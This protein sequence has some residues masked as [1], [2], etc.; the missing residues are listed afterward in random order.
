VRDRRV[1]CIQFCA[2]V[3][4]C[5]A[6]VTACSNNSPSSSISTTTTVKSSTATSTTTIAL[7]IVGDPINVYTLALGDCFNRYETGIDV[8]TTRVPCVA[9]HEG[10]VYAT[11]VHPSPF[12]DPWP[13]DDALQRYGLRLCYQNFESFA[14]IIYELSELGI[15][16]LTP[17]QANWEDERAR[18][19]GITCY[20]QRN[21]SQ[22]MVGSMRGKA[23]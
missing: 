3:V 23:L 21:D 22:P 9:S 11:L 7:S 8:I 16:V 18:Y 6:V 13:G 15:G 14:G 17:P 4:A 19:R 20:V 5:L 10:E 12:G 1:L 2:V